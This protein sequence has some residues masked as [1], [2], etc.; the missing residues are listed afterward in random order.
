MNQREAF[1]ETLEIARANGL[2]NRIIAAD[3]GGI[4]FSET[5]IGRWLGWA[6]AAVVCNG[7]G[8]LNDM[9]E[10]NMRHK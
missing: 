7:G 2:D 8:D 5:K 3:V 4:P 9:K 6:Q 10:I 1:R